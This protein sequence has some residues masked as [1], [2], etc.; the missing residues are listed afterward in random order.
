MNILEKLHKLTKNL[1][2]LYVEDDTDLRNKTSAML[3]NLFKSIDTASNGKEGFELYTKYYN[4]NDKHYDMVITDIKMPI[5][6]G[7]CLSKKILNLNKQQIIVVTSAHD[8]SKY[9]IEFINLNINKFISKPFSLDTITSMFLDLFE[10]YSDKSFHVVINEDYYWCKQTKKLF[11]N[12]EEVKL[13]YNEIS[14]LDVLITN[15]NKIFS[16]YDLFCSISSS[17]LAYEV[18]E[19]TI[20]SA[21]KR[22]RKKL[23]ENTISNIYGQG[24]SITLK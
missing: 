12:C 4:A 17:S 14:I 21:I 16:N 15:K 23:P 9:L 19:N 20:K 18:T 2:V 6:D 8:E 10:K 3:Q 5:V 7:L 1:V 24:Y 22:L 13:S 11:H